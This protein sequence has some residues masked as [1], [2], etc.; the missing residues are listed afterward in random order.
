V[1]DNVVPLCQHISRDGFGKLTV[2]LVHTMGDS[3]W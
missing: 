3:E 1:Y 2:P